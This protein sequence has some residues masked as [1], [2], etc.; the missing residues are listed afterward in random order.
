MWKMFLKKSFHR[1]CLARY[2]D[3]LVILSFLISYRPMYLYYS[4]PEI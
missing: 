1:I 4:T 3:L 2:E